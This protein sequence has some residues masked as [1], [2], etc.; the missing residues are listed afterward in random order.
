MK[1][2]SIKFPKKK[3]IMM[4][5]RNNYNKTTKV[6]LFHPFTIHLKLH[7]FV[8][9]YIYDYFDDQ[10][11]FGRKP[12]FAGR[13]LAHHFNWEHIAGRNLAVQ[14]FLFFYIY[15]KRKELEL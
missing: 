3:G 7:N 8:F 6:S 5:T 13:D 10:R 9:S 12:A 4:T 15:G 14:N 1:N 2:E 11:R